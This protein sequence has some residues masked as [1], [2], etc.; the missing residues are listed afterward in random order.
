MVSG[1]AAQLS[2]GDIRV[3][4]LRNLAT[5]HLRNAIK[6]HQDIVRIESENAGEPFGGFFDNIMDDW[7]SCILSCGASAETFL[8]EIMK[9]KSFSEQ[10]QN[11]IRSL[12]LSK[13]TKEFFS[14][15][16]GMKINTGSQPYQEMQ[17]V[18][19]LRSAV[20]HY[21]PHWDDEHGIS[22]ELA[23]KIPKCKPN[24]F[25]GAHETF[26][27]LRCISSGYSEWAV[28]TTISFMKKLVEL[29]DFKRRIA[30][31]RKLEEMFERRAR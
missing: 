27:P 22:H 12:N 9:E 16:F 14:L 7:I 20:M 28:K 25:V 24:P 18:Y 10:K 11:D 30:G 31:I 21:K 19:S 17:L 4:V 29:G 3:R 13:R 5:P 23:E 6:R 26:F 8:N 1:V 15:E 2:V